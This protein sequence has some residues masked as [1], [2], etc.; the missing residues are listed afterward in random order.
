MYDVLSPFLSMINKKNK[1]RKEK[2]ILLVVNDIDFFLSHRKKIGL[3][4]KEAGYRFLVCAPKNKNI[5][6]L[7]GL[8]L[9]YCEYSL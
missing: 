6:I 5:E 2:S 9:E 1:D 8:G 4:A 3:K 7:T